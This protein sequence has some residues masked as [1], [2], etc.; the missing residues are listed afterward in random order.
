MVLCHAT[1]DSSRQSLEVLRIHCR[2]GARPTLPQQY[3]CRC[4]YCRGETGLMGIC[5]YFC[6]SREGRSSLVD[7]SRRVAQRPMRG[8]H[9]SFF[10]LTQRDDTTL[11][12]H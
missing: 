3:F 4:P 1:C 12:V 11:I 9:F 5:L 6:P 7:C 8:C 2:V 10:P